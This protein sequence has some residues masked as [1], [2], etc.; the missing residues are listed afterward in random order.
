MESWTIAKAMLT[1]MDN[2][3]EVVL[4]TDN[5]DFCLP[6]CFTYNV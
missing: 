2:T 6:L 5:C 3:Q 1:Y 4:S